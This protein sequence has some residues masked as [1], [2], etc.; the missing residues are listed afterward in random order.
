MYKYYDIPCYDVVQFVREHVDEK[1]IPT[2]CDSQNISFK[3]E[4][5]LSKAEYNMVVLNKLLVDET[6]GIT[7]EEKAAIEYAIECIKTL[8][9]MGII[10]ENN[11]D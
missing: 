2:K 1:I 3:I 8:D 5:D 7:E 11:D 9:D 10:K 4:N 6:A